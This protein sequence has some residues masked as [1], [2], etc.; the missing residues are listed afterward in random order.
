MQTCQLEKQ[1]EPPKTGLVRCLVSKSH[2]SEICNCR[3][4]RDFGSLE[5]ITLTITIAASLRKKNPLA[6]W[7][8]PIVLC[9]NTLG[10]Y[11]S[12]FLSNIL[13]NRQLELNSE[14]RSPSRL[15][16][17]QQKDSGKRDHG[18]P[19]S[20]DAVYQRTS[21]VRIIVLPVG[22]C[23][24]LEKKRKRFAVLK[25]LSMAVYGMYDPL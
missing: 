9:V 23:R 2:G 11:F 15:H 1:T 3:V 5:R 21:V 12:A 19:G 18:V 17:R 16:Y 25:E 4:Q 13:S 10:Y 14:K 20:R 8:R 22:R 24:F 6:P 7:V